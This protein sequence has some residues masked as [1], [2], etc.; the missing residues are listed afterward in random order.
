[1]NEI[2]EGNEYFTLKE[3]LHKE[4][5][6]DSLPIFG[7]FEYNKPNSDR[8]GKIKIKLDLE[9]NI[10]SLNKI[11]EIIKE[12]YNSYLYFNELK[13]KNDDNFSS[14]HLSYKEYRSLNIGRYNTYKWD[15][16]QETLPKEFEYYIKPVLIN[17]IELFS[18]FRKDDKNYCFSIVDGAFKASL[19]SGH[20][21]ATKLAIFDLIKRI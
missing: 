2:I 13:M 14:E 8:Y 1:M 3:N 18:F 4:I 7:E 11:E 21:M 20:Q 10:E 16:N 6:I 17:F 5:N 12:N 19:K 15:V 9:H